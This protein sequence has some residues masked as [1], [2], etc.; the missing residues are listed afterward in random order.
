MQASSGESKTSQ[1]QTEECEDGRFGHS[2]PRFF[3]IDQ[4]KSCRLT[5]YKNT[6]VS[7]SECSIRN[8]RRCNLTPTNFV[9]A[10]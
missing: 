7:A 3:K 6:N 9:D 10:K 1:R 2:I 5:F 8:A 4:A